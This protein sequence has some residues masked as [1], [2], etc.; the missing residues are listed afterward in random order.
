MHCH[1]DNGICVG[2]HPVDIG[3]QRDL[4]HESC[5][6]RLFC[7]VAIVRKVRLE[8]HDVFEPAEGFRVAFFLQRIGV[9]R[10]G[11]QLIVKLIQR[12]IIQR[13]LQVENH[14]GEFEQCSRGTGQFRIAAGVCNDIKQIRT[15]A[16][17]QIQCGFYGFISDFPRRNID[18]PAQTQIIRGVENHPE[19]CQ[20]IADFCT[21]KESQTADNTV[22]DTVSLER[23]LDV[24]G[25]DVIA[26]QNCIVT[27]GVPL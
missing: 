5:E 14:F 23:V 21:V 2:I 27:P 1:H 3:K 4:F 15:V 16:V 10:D 25:E 22:W 20:H 26:V 12:Q 6:R 7:A 19:I 13:T 18:N 9:S 17:S 11:Q 8:F 24:V